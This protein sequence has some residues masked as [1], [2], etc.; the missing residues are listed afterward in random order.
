MLLHQDN[1]KIIIILNWNAPY[2]PQF[3][4]LTMPCH[5]GLHQQT[6]IYTW[7]HQGWEI[8][9]L[10]QS[11]SNSQ[12]AS[13]YSSQI[14]FFFVLA[15]SVFFP[16]LRPK[17]FLTPSSLALSY[18]NSFLLK[19]TL[20]ILN[21]PLYLLAALNLGPFLDSFVTAN[22]QPFPNDMNSLLSKLLYNPS[23]LS[24]M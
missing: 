1:K 22:S 3:S 17:A 24:V 8:K 23:I 4:L 15:L 21:I 5:G 13:I 7:I 10:R 11:I 20:K 16:W 12:S 2:T 14:T 6:Q 18:S 19:S 9:M